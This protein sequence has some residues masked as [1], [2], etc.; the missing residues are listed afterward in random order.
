MIKELVHELCG[1]T[2][3]TKLDLKSSYHQI[4]MSDE[5][6]PKI[7][8]CTPEGHYEFLVMPFGLANAPA[9]FEALMNEVL[10]PF[11]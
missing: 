10:K 11:L 4:Q 1:T 7:T 2:I 5:D 3:F 9:T 8:F 6:V